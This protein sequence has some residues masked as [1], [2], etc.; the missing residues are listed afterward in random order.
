MQ[1]ILNDVVFY[2]PI[3]ITAAAGAAAAL[4]QGQPG[5]LWAKIRGVVDFLAMNFGNAKNAA[6]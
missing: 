1:T 6:K 2:G 4:P 3:I 5:S